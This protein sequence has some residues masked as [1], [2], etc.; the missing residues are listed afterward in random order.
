MSTPTSPDPR[1]RTG[2]EPALGPDG[3]A[4]TP[5]DPTGSSERSAPLSAQHAEPRPAPPAVPRTDEHTAVLPATDAATPPAATPVPVASQPVTPPV[6]SRRTLREDP[7]AAED[8]RVTEERRLSEDRRLEAE[9]RELELELDAF[10]GPFDL[11]LT[12]LLK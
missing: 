2:S 5:G 7:G 11:L 9:R 3:A 12:L 4:L 6:E 1:E 8:R 10:E